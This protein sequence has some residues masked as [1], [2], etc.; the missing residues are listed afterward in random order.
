[1]WADGGQCF[2]HMRS[3][4]RYLGFSGNFSPEKSCLDLSFYYKTFA[5]LVDLYLSTIQPNWVEGGI[6]L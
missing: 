4:G 1:M 3:S 5:F 6:Y 2:L